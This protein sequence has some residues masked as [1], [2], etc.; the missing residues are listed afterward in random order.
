MRKATK[1][2]VASNVIAFPS[3]L[4][5]MKRCKDGTRHKRVP[6]KAGDV[7]VYA[8]DGMTSID[9]CVPHAVAARMLAAMKG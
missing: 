2:N 7:H 4:V 8:G 9:A 1:A 6:T 3:H 5:G